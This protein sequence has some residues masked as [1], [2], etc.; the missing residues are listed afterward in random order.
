[1]KFR[2]IQSND[3]GLVTQVGDRTYARRG[4]ARGE[5]ATELPTLFIWLKKPRRL[6]ARC[7]TRWSGDMLER[8]YIYEVTRFRGVIDLQG[9]SRYHQWCSQQL[10]L[11][12]WE[13]T[14]P[15]VDVSQICCPEPEA[16]HEP[17]RFKTAQYLE[18]RKTRLRAQTP[19][20]TEGEK[21]ILSDLYQFRDSLNQ[22]AGHIAYHVDHI[23]PLALGGLHHPSNLRVTT[24]RE[25][26]TKGAKDC[27]L[28]LPGQSVIAG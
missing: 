26:M 7:W 3:R 28:P 21:E 1:M 23:K 19:P 17:E 15:V 12:M 2:V 11:Q 24:S 25:N 8:D 20:L 6:V 10:R 22:A 14:E 16:V 4:P 9:D 27:E 5:E 18:R 13:M